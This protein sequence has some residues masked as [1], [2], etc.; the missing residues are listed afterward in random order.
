MVLLIDGGR[1]VNVLKGARALRTATG[2]DIRLRSGPSDGAITVRELDETWLTA[3][4]TLTNRSRRD[5]RIAHL[6]LLR[7]KIATGSAFGG[8]A[9][10]LRMLSNPRG[11]GY[12]A[13]TRDL[14]PGK[15]PDLYDLGPIRPNGGLA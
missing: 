14:V 3:A 5:V 15:Q 6:D 1:E 9:R 11:M 8:T 10:G 2:V 13:G 12:F 7:L 4:V